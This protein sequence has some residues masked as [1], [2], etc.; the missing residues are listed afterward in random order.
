MVTAPSIFGNSGGATFLEETGE[1]IGVPA[2]ITVAALGFSADVIT[3]MGF[4]ITAERI[5]QFLDDQVFD[6]VYGSGRTSTECAEERKDK[7]DADLHQRAN[8]DEDEE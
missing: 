8:R 2:R 6:F 7:R 3:H 4:S 1:M 5:Y